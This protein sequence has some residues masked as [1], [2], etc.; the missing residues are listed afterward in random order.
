LSDG[1]ES[2]A[3]CWCAGIIL[4]I[5]GLYYFVT[6][7]LIPVIIPAVLLAAGVAALI[8][9]IVGCI[10]GLVCY[11]LS[12]KKNIFESA[13]P[14]AKV[15]G[16]IIIIGLILTAVSAGYIIYNQYQGTGI[17]YTATLTT[18]VKQPYSWSQVYGFSDYTDATRETWNI[19]LDMT[20]EM[21]IKLAYLPHN[22]HYN[23][24]FEPAIEII[25]YDSN[26]K[27][28]A[29]KGYGRLPYAK[30]GYGHPESDT[31]EHLKSGKY[32]ICMNG[33]NIDVNVYVTGITT[34]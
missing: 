22:N 31:I 29:K 30:D 23:D 9:I 21:K 5:V 10:I 26:G 13:R 33:R 15:V 2:P 28:V 8:G 25:V 12:L 16:V 3:I 34:C 1:G 24:H 14:V 6:L 19:K 20:P 4:L 27:E 11:G 18:T 17:F 7:I 32:T